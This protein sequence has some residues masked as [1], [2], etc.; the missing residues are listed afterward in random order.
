MSKTYKYVF[1]DLDHTLWDFDANAEA[2]L[3]DLYVLHD[4]AGVG[5]VSEDSFI[6]DFFETNAGLWAQYNVGQIDKFYLRNQR[7]R[8]IF[9]AAGAIMNLV[10]DEYLKEFNKQ[11]L[12]NCPRQTRLMDGT[13]EV[14]EALHAKYPMHIITNGFEEVQSH[15]MECSKI[16][17]YF[18]RVITSEKA[19][20]KKPFAGIFNYA[21]KWTGANAAESIMIGDNLD[22]DIKGA[23]DYGM[24]QVFFNP[25]GNL[26]SE[27]VTY[28][29]RNLR[30]LLEIL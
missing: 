19:G 29:I 1:F 6:R 9:E 13:I 8:L 30:E 17:K 14:L 24:D 20:F 5:I 15:K 3:R 25:D 12:H 23:R 4:L 22:A 7:F 11:F 2:V 28:E 10:S 26:H 18:D 16:A 21:M 27:E